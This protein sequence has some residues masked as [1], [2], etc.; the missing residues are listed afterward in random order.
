MVNTLI[1]QTKRTGKRKAKVGADGLTKHQRYYL[2][3]PE[4]KIKNLLRERQRREQAREER[5]LQSSELN[6]STMPVESTELN[7]SST[8]GVPSSA[9]NALDSN[10]IGNG[11][12]SGV[13][14]AS[15]PKANA[16]G[17]VPPYLP[18]DFLYQRTRVWPVRDK[19]MDD[20]LDR[21]FEMRESVVQWARG[22]GGIDSWSV[23][24]DYSYQHALK[25]EGPL[26]PRWRKS[27]FTHARGGRE[28]L[29]NLR[30]YDSDLPDEI[31]MQEE[32]WRVRIELAEQL[33][34]GITI[35]EI[36]ASILPGVCNVDHCCQSSDDG[37]AQCSDEGDS[38]ETYTD[39]DA[40]F[41]DVEG[42]E[43]LSNDG[44]LYGSGDEDVD[45][46]GEID[47]EA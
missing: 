41:D 9:T 1:S 38:D 28:M 40:A 34:K 47:D 35:L 45:A 22:W 7:A 27:M 42:D 14:Q 4:V 11:S 13:T 39:S 17:P 12:P 21:L 44:D 31:W 26:T 23:Q 15:A 32:I 33:V 20:S 2:S 29:A 25:E 6:E 37:S 36:K 8:F 46:D 19:T 18:R 30:Q 3:H 43:G 16:D 10:S 5:L 24:L